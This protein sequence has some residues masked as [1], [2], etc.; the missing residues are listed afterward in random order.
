M[1][2][3]G[4]ICESPVDA[5]ADT[6]W[7]DFSSVRRAVVTKRTVDDMVDLVKV[8]SRLSVPAVRGRQA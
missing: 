6:E 2:R 3:A 8:K 4:A 1:A 7:E 5:A